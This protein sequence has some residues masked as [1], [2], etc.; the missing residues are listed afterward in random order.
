MTTVK[1]SEPGTATGSRR[2]LRPFVWLESSPITEVL[3]ADAAAGLPEL[4]AYLGQQVP[5]LMRSLVDFTLVDS[6]DRTSRRAVS[7]SVRN[8]RR[9]CAGLWI[10]A[11]LA[12][13]VEPG[14]L[15]SLVHT[16]GP[17]LAGT[18]PLPARALRK[19]KNCLEF[20]RGAMTGMICSLPEANLVPQAKAIHCLETVLAIH[21]RAIENC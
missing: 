10:H 19:T 4:E 7:A 18:G 3:P 21:L 14:M 8:R 5:L 20:L 6:Q 1:S 12:G 11:I 17:Q 9:R 16:W 15:E 13:S 2:E